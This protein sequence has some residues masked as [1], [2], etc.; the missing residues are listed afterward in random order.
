MTSGS[1]RIF[2]LK[3]GGADLKKFEG[4]KQSVIHIFS[5]Y[6]GNFFY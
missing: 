3:L 6:F 1:V 5:G 2:K 4:V